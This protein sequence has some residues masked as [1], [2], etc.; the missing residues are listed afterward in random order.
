MVVKACGMAVSSFTVDSV[1]RG[2]H[3]YKDIWT[4][5]VGEEL[6]LEQ[7]QGNQH[8]FYATTVKKNGVVVGRVPREL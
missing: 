8:D 6:F 5:Y 2:H 7:E 1:I 4:P 3:V